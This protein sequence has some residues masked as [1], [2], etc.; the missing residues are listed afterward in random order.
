MIFFLPPNTEREAFPSSTS[1]V[2][3]EDS[4]GNP[5]LPPASFSLCLSRLV[6]LGLRYCYGFE[7]CHELWS[8]R[9]DQRVSERE[10]ASVPAGPD[11]QASVSLLPDCGAA[12]GLP[13]GGRCSHTVRAV[14][15]AFSLS[16]PKR[17]WPWACW[18]SRKCGFFFR[19][20]G[21]CQCDSLCWP[22]DDR[23]ACVSWI[24][25][26]P[27]VELYHWLQGEG[28]GGL[29]TSRW[30]I[31]REPREPALSYCSHSGPH[32][33]LLMCGPHRLK[34][35][36]EKR[37]F[38]KRSLTLWKWVSVQVDSSVLMEIKLK[39]WGQPWVLRL[40]TLNLP[41]SFAWCMLGHAPADPE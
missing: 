9:G 41:V 31:V 1:S 8:M 38:S 4:Q 28:T 37:A 35:R 15:D 5:K 30:L 23:L 21:R 14:L 33:I 16:S 20:G 36:E 7:R 26:D 17:R 13:D 2:L 19:P 34:R 10:G 12:S 6:F 22:F 29:V 39:Q 3:T 18:R 25:P 40:L 27:L 32:F 11:P 24:P